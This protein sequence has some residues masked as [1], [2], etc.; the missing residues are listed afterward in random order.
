MTDTT[1]TVALAQIAPVWLDR[2]GTLEK[3]KTAVAEAADKGASLVTFGESLLPGYPF[4]LE[5][6]GGAIFNSAK[7]KAIHARYLQ[8]AVSIESGHLDELC[9]LAAQRHIAVVL[10]TAERAGDRGG[11]SLYC[12][13]VYISKQGHIANVH[14]K[15]MPTYEER[16]TWSPGDGHGLRTFPLQPFTLGALNCWENWMPLARAALYGQGEDLHVAIWPGGEHNTQD[17]TRFIAKEGRSYVMSVSGLMRPADFPDDT[18][19]LAEILHNAPE[20]LAS[21]ASCIAAPDGGWVIEPQIGNEGVF[22]ADIDHLRVLEERQN[23]DPVGHY[24]RPDVTQLQV[25]RERQSTVRFLDP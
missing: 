4:W 23:F 16:L 19:E 12:S 7:Q 22:V 8:Q 18:P 24:S 17:I 14:R 6:T 3:I 15:L 13:L 11:H 5:R 10:G 9:R 2:E 20:F 21:G 25:N 1:L